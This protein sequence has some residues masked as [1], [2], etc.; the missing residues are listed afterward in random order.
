MPKPGSTK[1]GGRFVGPTNVSPAVG[2]FTLADLF[3]ADAA[4]A[5]AVEEAG[6]AQRRADSI[7]A[8]LTEVYGPV[9]LTAVHGDVPGMPVGALGVSIANRNDPKGTLWP[10]KK[11]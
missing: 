2:D 7:A 4:A 1:I 11:S 10:A 6:Q 9:I 5:K 3:A 8:R